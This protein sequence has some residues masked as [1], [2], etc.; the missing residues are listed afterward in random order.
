MAKSKNGSVEATKNGSDGQKLG[1]RLSSDAASLLGALE[2]TLREGAG[3]VVVKA[4]VALADSLPRRQSEGVEAMMRVH[5]A[6]LARLRKSCGPTVAESVPELSGQGGAATT[7][8][9]VDSS[10]VVPQ[11][12]ARTST[13]TAMFNRTHAPIDEALDV[14]G[15][16]N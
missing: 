13:I 4:L 9:V 10:A 2:Y 12:G 3:S 6:S 8:G 15:G 14:I 1:C 16:G 11:L 5:G 7:S